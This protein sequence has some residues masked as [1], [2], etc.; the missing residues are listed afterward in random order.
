[1][2]LHLGGSFGSDFVLASARSSGSCGYLAPGTLSA[3]AWS[4]F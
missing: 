2:N 4:L 1:M 3:S